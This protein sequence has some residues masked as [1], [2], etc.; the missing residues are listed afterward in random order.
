MRRGCRK[1]IPMPAIDDAVPLAYREL[2]LVRT[3][4]AQREL[5]FAAFTDPRYLAQWWGPHGFTNPVCEFNA[6]PGGALRIHMRGPDGGIY[7]AQGV[8]REI[9]TPERLVFTI[10][11]RE[12]GGGIRLENLTSVTFVEGVDVEGGGVEGTGV[13]GTGVEGVDVEGVDVEGGGAEHAGKTTLTLH[14]RVLQATAAATANLAGMPVGWSQ[15][16]DRLGALLTE[17]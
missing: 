2:T 4:D 14:V 8:V 17:L 6:R 10:A 1:A 3:F 7:K 11:V 13:E 15:S 9:V 12:D 5:V 16:L